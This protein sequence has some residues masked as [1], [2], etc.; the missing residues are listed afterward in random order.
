MRDWPPRS[1]RSS[2]TASIS[3]R[4]PNLGQS[5]IRG[6]DWGDTKAALRFG[7]DE[8]REP[9]SVR[10]RCHSEVQAMAKEAPTADPGE[11]TN[12]GSHE[13]TDK[14]WNGNPE[15]EQWNGDDK[16]DLEKWQETNTH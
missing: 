15:K 7:D 5:F 3:V 16:L 2:P 4:Y 6:I 1:R 10:R 14:P 12:G 13:Q 8:R 11:R 9:F